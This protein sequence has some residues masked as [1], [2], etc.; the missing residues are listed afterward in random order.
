MKSHGLWSSVWSALSP[1]VL[2]V[3]QWLGHCDPAALSQLHRGVW[4]LHPPPAP[5]KAQ[6]RAAAETD[7]T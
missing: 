2:A 4:G 5:P 7:N 1:E 3:G 6:G